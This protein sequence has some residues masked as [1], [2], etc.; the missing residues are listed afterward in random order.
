MAIRKSSISG[1]PSGNTDN[2]P[3]NPEIGATY[4]NGTLGVEEIYTSAGWV[5]KS[6]PA[7]VP[8]NVVATNQGSGRAYNNGQASVA[9]SD[10]AGGG[11]VTDY[12]VTPSPATS[13]STFTGSSSPITVTGL[14]SSQQYTYTLQA[15]NNFGTSLL[16]AASAAVTA[17]TVPDTPTLSAVGTTDAS[18][19]ATI[20]ITPGATGGSAITQYSIISNP[21]TTTQTTSNTTYTFTGLTLLT[22]YTFTVTAT[23][24]EGT[25][26]SSVQSNSITPTGLFAADYLVIAGGGGGGKANGGG[27]GGAGGY[28]TSVGTSGRNSAA[29][30]SA[31]IGVVTNYTVTVGAGG[32]GVS[33]AGPLVNG[34]G[35]SSTFTTIISEGGGQGGDSD[36]PSQ[37]A[38]GGN[39][40]SGG[41]AGSTGGGA[42]SAGVGTANQGFDG[43]TGGSDGSSYRSGGGGGGAGSSGSNYGGHSGG[44]GG[45]GLSSSID[46]SNL[47]RA[48]GGGGG[49]YTTGGASGGN[50]GGGTGSGQGSN[51]SSGT[52]NTGGGGGGGGRD[53]EAYNGGSGIVIIRYPSAKTITVGAGLTSSTATVG[54]NKV[55]TFTAGTGTISFS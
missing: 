32:P 42:F 34:K 51:G 13:P 44:A 37:D 17:T 12:I 35:N 48:G 3:A 22:A 46:G 14:Q 9:F 47:T 53:N 10:G 4:N 33:S 29:E 39:G 50:G 25:S 54:E 28:R 24:A 18:S 36:A 19:T 27:G 43:G 21:A 5:A 55:T 2:R 52:A 11:L 26:A 16:S 23:N 8:I 20:T 30:S 41:G 15:R 6:A 45:N 49:S 31:T 7:S 1:T 40:G 38:P